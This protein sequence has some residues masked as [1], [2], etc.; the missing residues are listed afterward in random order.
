MH[1]LQPVKNVGIN[2]DSLHNLRYLYGQIGIMPTDNVERLKTSLLRV[3]FVLLIL[4]QDQEQSVVLLCGPSKNTDILERA[5]RSAYLNPLNLPEEYHGTAFEILQEMQ[6]KVDYLQH[7]IDEQKATLAEL[8]QTRK[9]QFQNL[10]W[11]VRISRML[12][13]AMSHFGKLQHTYLLVGWIPSNQF[14]NISRKIKDISDDIVIESQV[15]RRGNTDQNT[16]VLLNNRGIFG[17]FQILVTTYGKPRYE[18]VDPTILLAITFPLLFGAMFGDVGHGLILTLLGGLL[19]SGKVK[20]LRGMSGFGTIITVCGLAAIGFGFLYGS[21][22][23]LETL[24]PALWLRPMDNILEIL[25]ITVV[26]GVVIL[27]LAYFINFLNAWKAK[28]WSRL[29]LGGTGISGFLLYWGLIGLAAS[30]MQK[31]IPLPTTPFIILI[32]IASIL[33]MFSDLLSN[34]LH[35][36]RPLIE[37]DLATYAIQIFFEL[38]ETLISLFSNSLSYV[39]V[40]AFAVAHAGLSAVI[41]ILADMI[42]ATQG[43]G[44]WITLVIG[45]IFII[46]FE[47][48]IVAIQT[49]RLEYYEFLSKFFTGGGKN[50]SP[51]VLK[52][53]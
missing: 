26:A 10:L 4:E 13:D 40:G 29:L 6:A 43:P 18:E 38:F 32:F 1:Q 53:S 46:G 31:A 47:G 17:A 41:F 39:R 49:L 37:G 33:V 9:V 21:I 52:K 8:R 23:G 12:T 15:H 2:L 36:H 25:I 5:A 19:A 27:N 16:P 50:F 44:Y 14:S 3:P 34:L 7:Q 20:S 45:N 30:L 22:F 28:D 11:R 35:N 24:L 48:M 51:L 42:S